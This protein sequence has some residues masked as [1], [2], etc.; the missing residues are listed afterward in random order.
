VEDSIAYVKNLH[1]RM[2]QL[3]ERKV[4][5]TE[6]AGRARLA[7]SPQ[8][9]ASTLFLYPQLNENLLPRMRLDSSSASTKE[10]LNKFHEF[11]GNCVTKLHLH[12]DNSLPHKFSIEMLCRPQPCLQS[13][14]FLCFESLFLE[15]KQCTITT[16]RNFVMCVILAQVCNCCQL[17][18]PFRS[19]SM[20]ISPK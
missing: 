10:D 12:L 5:M 4:I 20:L 14:I 17:Y 11:F 7:Q 2:K 1:H 16:V 15:I 6:L 18:C 8:Q 13:Q 3:Q 19:I 9:T